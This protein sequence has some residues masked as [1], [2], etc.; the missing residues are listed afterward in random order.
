MRSLARCA[1]L[2]PW[3]IP[4]FDVDHHLELGYGLLPFAHSRF[5]TILL[6]GLVF[7]TRTRIFY[8]FPDLCIALVCCDKQK[9]VP[10]LI[11]H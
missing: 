5:L 3:I 11:D 9:D 6:E 4:Q 2:P 8:Q 7:D 1:T 10:S